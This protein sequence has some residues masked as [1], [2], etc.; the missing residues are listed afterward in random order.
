[1]TH[2]HEPVDGSVST[3]KRLSLCEMNAKACLNMNRFGLGY[4]FQAVIILYGMVRGKV[5]ADV[6]NL[7]GK[8]IPPR[9]LG[10]KLPVLFRY[11]WSTTRATIPLLRRKFC[12][13]VYRW[14]CPAIVA[15]SATYQF[16]LLY[17]SYSFTRNVIVF[18]IY[19]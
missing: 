15:C 9:F 3:K 11:G 1:M 5:R 2:M 17:L 19:R 14:S 16:N 12:R 7:Q 18:A 6:Y 4:G 8:S 13:E 10:Q